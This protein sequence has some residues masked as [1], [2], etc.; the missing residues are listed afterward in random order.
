MDHSLVFSTVYDTLPE[1]QSHD[2]PQ[3][4]KVR[5]TILYKE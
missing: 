4:P 3:D 1:S 2:P 5:T